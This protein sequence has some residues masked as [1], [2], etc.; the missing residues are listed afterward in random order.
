MRHAQSGIGIEPELPDHARQVA[1][2]GDAR[3]L[4]IETQ[5]EAIGY[6][7][8]NTQP[9]DARE[10]SVVD[11]EPVCNR[12]VAATECRETWR[13]PDPEIA[14]CAES[15]DLKARERGQRGEPECAATRA[16]A[17]YT[18]AA[19]TSLLETSTNA[20]SRVLMNPSAIDVSTGLLRIVTA[21]ASTPDRA[22][23]ASEPLPVMATFS[24][25]IP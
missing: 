18:D 11:V 14:Q 13:W 24:A 16:G 21:R 17:L 20:L 12:G 1:E 3:Q 22:M 7:V 6:R 4:V 5:N 25:D 2:C 15:G 8:G 10:G 19:A 23:L 9:V